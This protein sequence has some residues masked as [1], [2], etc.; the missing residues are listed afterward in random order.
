MVNACPAESDPRPKVSSFVS[1]PEVMA[2]AGLV[3]EGTDVLIDVV[4]E[5]L[6]RQEPDSIIVKVDRDF[7]A[8]ED[9]TFSRELGAYIDERLAEGKKLNLLICGDIPIQGWN[10]ILE[11]YKG[12]NFKVYYFATACRQVP[13]CT[14]ILI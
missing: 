5:E 4:T 1:D 3:V 8:D 10:L 6:V 9:I 14:K 7:L 2:L 12:M 11:K 13:L